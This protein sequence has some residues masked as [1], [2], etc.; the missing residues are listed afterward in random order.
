M[1][2]EEECVARYLAMLHQFTPQQRHPLHIQ[3]YTHH[4]HPQH[5]QTYPKTIPLP[6]KN[7]PNNP[8]SLPIISLTPFLSCTNNPAKIG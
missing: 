4:N 6:P 8:S 7:S 1:S 3:G 2:T 5:T